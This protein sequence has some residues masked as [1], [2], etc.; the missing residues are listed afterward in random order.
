MDP[1]EIS[2]EDFKNLGT[3]AFDINAITKVQNNACPLTFS[4]SELQ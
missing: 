4:K 2:V 3:R 1:G